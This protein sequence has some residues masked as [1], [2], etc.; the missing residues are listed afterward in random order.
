MCVLAAKLTEIHD[1]IPAN[2]AIMNN[3]IP[4][5]KRNGVPLLDFEATGWFLSCGGTGTA[6]LKS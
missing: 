2:R 5:P 3:D 1:M 6:M 4:S